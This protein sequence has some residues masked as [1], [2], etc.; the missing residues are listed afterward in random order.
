MYIYVV[1]VSIN[2]RN[3]SST[4]GVEWPV[5]WGMHEAGQAIDKVNLL[6]NP[7]FRMEPVLL[8]NQRSCRESRD[9]LSKDIH[10]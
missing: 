9:L 2:I 8:E 3:Y 5:A 4:G 1:L 7:L 10:I 6:F